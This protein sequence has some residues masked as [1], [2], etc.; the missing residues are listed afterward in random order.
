MIVQQIRSV[1][2]TALAVI[3][4]SSL[5]NAQ[6]ISRPDK[7]VVVKPETLPETV[8]VPGGAI[9]Q[10]LVEAR[11]QIMDDDVSSSAGSVYDDASSYVSDSAASV[12]SYVSD[13]A[14]SASSYAADVAASARQVASGP[15]SLCW[16]AWKAS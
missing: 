8:R 7:I 4:P 1:T 12:S 10:V 2:I 11:E 3:I 9:A 5:S 14:A 13:S 15:A 6:V 16:H